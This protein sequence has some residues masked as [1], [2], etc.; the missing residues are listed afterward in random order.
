VDLVSELMRVPDS[1]YSQA[2]DIAEKRDMSMKEA[3]RFMCRQG[4]FDV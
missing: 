3:I 4:S 1:V 2:K